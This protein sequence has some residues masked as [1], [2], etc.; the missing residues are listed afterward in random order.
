M[1]SI[2]KSRTLSD[3]QVNFMTIETHLA[4]VF[5]FFLQLQCYQVGKF[6]PLSALL[7]FSCV[8]VCVYT[9]ACA[10]LHVSALSV[11]CACTCVRVCI[12]L[13][14]IFAC[15]CVHVCV[16]IECFVCMHM[17]ACVCVLKLGADSGVSLY[18]SPLY[19]PFIQNSH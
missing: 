12:M 8:C 1:T 14:H 3:L 10:C 4:I 2:S 5:F 9:F 15:A 7:S 13:V 17:H 6:Y 18:H 16:C 19:H 11:L